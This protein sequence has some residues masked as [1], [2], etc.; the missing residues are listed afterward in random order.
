MD[1]EFLLPLII[2]LISLVYQIIDHY[3]SKKQITSTHVGDNYNFYPP[4]EKIH[5][6]QYQK[7]TLFINK[8]LSMLSMY[9]YLIIFLYILYKNFDASLF[10]KHI[11]THLQKNIEAL[12]NWVL[13]S[14]YEIA[15]SIFILLVAISAITIIGIILNK[16][17]GVSSK[18]FH[19][20][21]LICVIIVNFIYFKQFINTN[22]ASF[23][24]VLTNLETDSIAE[25]I[26][27]MSKVYAIMFIIL[28]LLYFAFST[29]IILSI[30]FR[31]ISLTNDYSYN[32]KNMLKYG[33]LIC[34]PLGLLFLFRFASS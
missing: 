30:A 29:Y 8:K 10:T 6:D 24:N 20:I 32:F 25:F 18:W 21:F 22:Y 26:K 19:C 34:I 11:F 33:S 4:T 23:I 15:P 17:I 2:S 12:F 7:N 5:T 3:A 27:K 16:K 31:P 1:I 13:S 9:S 14:I 28:Q